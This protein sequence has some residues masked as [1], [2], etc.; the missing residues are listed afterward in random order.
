MEK[1]GVPY[2][3]DTYIYAYSDRPPTRDERKQREKEPLTL[4]QKRIFRAIKKYVENIGRGPTKREVMRL[5]GHRSTSTTNGFLDIL[6]KKNWIIFD[7]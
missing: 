4:K 1:E 6:N 5:A 2:E 7:G 3:E